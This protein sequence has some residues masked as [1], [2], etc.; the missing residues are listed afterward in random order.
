MSTD[1][2]PLE[3][4]VAVVTG[5]GRG[6]GLMLAE[7]LVRAG[8]RAY[9]CSRKASD[10]QAAV[11]ALSPLGDVRSVAAD[12]ATPDGVGVVSEHVAEHEPRVHVLVNNAGATWGAPLEQFP[13]AAWDR[14]L[15][16]N[17]KGTFLLTQALLPLLRAASVPGDPS[18]VVNIGSVDGLRPPAPHYNNFSYSASKAAVH[19]LTRHLASEL[20]PD[21]LVNAIAPGLF[22][23]KMTAGVL[24]TEGAAAAVTAQI[25]L[26]RIGR[27]EDIAGLGVFLASRASS[28]ITGAVI[29]LDGGLTGAR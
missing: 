11:E 24:A 19:M 15:D 22:E 20:A 4:K 25:P 26:R 1:Y 9:L 17:V 23:T 28:Y 8:A 6:I 2:R 5:G 27:P 21:V 3:G 14:V 18:R 13:P 12:L 10:L 29:P 7:G 16:L